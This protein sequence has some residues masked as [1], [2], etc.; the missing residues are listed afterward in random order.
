MIKFLKENWLKFWI[1]I[2]VLVTASG[3][4]YYYVRFLPTQTQLQF[5][6][7]QAAAIFAKNIDCQKYS[8]QV[9]SQ[10]GGFLQP[11]LVSGVFYSSK[12]NACLYVSYG[13]GLDKKIEV[14]NFVTGQDVFSENL[15]DMKQNT[16]GNEIS[17]LVSSYK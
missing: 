2:G 4:F 14:I 9:Q 15:K 3:I 17:A 5:E 8:S 11:S 13:A 16:V 7:N 10:T 1:A 6:Q 12:E